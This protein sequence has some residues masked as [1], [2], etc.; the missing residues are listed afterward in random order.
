M[1]QV[2][3][4]TGYFKETSSGGVW[5]TLSC[6]KG[7]SVAGFNVLLAATPPDFETMSD[8]QHD[9]VKAGVAV[10]KGG[11]VANFRAHIEALPCVTGSG[12]WPSGSPAAFSAA[13]SDDALRGLAYALYEQIGKPNAMASAVAHGG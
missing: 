4:N 9:L 5:V 12:P 6:H 13:A 1:G 7:S 11:D 3:A 10:V 8:I 2:E